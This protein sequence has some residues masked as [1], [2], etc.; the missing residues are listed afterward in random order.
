MRAE[1]IFIV[2]LCALSGRR[3]PHFQN[4]NSLIFYE[5]RADLFLHLGSRLSVTMTPSFKS[6]KNGAPAI[7]KSTFTTVAGDP[8]E[9]SPYET[10]NERR[11]RQLMTDANTVIIMAKSFQICHNTPLSVSKPKTTCSS[12]FCDDKQREESCILHLTHPY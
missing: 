8:T 12:P 7:P 2:P 9:L 10:K 6:R 3:T 1:L 4:P 5:L 11:L